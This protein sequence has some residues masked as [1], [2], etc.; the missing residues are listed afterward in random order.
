MIK[1]SVKFLSGFASKLVEASGIW[2]FQR[3]RFKKS[4]FSFSK[5]TVL[6]FFVF[7]FIFTLL[8]ITQCEVVF[9]TAQCEQTPVIRFLHLLTKHC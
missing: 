8:R 9:P 1:P 6:I 2:I 5:V 3:N 4:S 7:V